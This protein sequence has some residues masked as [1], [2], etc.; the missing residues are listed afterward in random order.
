MAL[1]SWA[2]FGLGLA[3]LTLWSLANDVVRRTI[4]QAGL[5]RYVAVCL[6]SGYAWA[7]AAGLLMTRLGTGETGMLYDAAL[8]ALFVGFVF[9]MVYGHAPVI[10]PAVLRVAV[11]YRPVFYLPLALLHASLGLRVA[12]DLLELHPLRQ[13]GGL[14]NAAA[15]AVFIVTMLATVLGAKRR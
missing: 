15:I 6:L 5:T 10:L 9:A 1:G 3:L 11:P 14:G 8:H 12:G 2:V 13:W 4:R 7:L